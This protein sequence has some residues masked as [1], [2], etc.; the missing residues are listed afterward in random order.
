MDTAIGTGLS[1]T[2]TLNTDG[3]FV[4]VPA[5][6]FIGQ[7]VGTYT[8]CD[9]GSSCSTATLTITVSAAPPTTDELYLSSTSL[10]GSTFGFDAAPAAVQNPEPDVDN[11]TKPG[12]TLRKDDQPL[13]WVHP[14]SVNT[15]LSGP[16]TLDLLSTRKNFESDKRISLAATLLI[17]DAGGANCST[18]LQR[19]WTFDPW[20]VAGA[21]T[22]TER[23]LTLGSLSTSVSA[24]RE[25][26]LVV[27]VTDDT[28]WIATSGGRPSS[29][30]LSL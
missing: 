24:G 11:D 28:L 5:M 14:V 15:N 13:V 25:L 4:Y 17:C 22:W 21:N 30:L 19:S 16:V 26:R 18:L 10:T 9:P 8:V 1:G 23:Q 27:D 20:N 3:S 2:I 12:W 7:D 6:L 29:L